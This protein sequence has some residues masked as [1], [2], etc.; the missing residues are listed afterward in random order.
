MQANADTERMHAVRCVPIC[1][2]PWPDRPCAMPVVVRQQGMMP[3]AWSTPAE[4]LAF[5]LKV[6]RRPTGVICVICGLCCRCC[7]RAEERQTRKDLGCETNPF[8]QKGLQNNQLGK[9]RSTRR[10]QNGADRQQPVRMDGSRGHECTR[11]AAQVCGKWTPMD[12]AERRMPGP[13]R[14]ALIRSGRAG[15]G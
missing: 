15:R 9:P 6:G 13:G 7:C 8:C 10:G 12:V 14:W 1:V 5:G 4:R 2:D 11:H 3:H